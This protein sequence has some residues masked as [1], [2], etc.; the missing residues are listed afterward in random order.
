L[1][2]GKSASYSELDGVP[3]SASRAVLTDLLRDR[4][5][6]TGTTVSD[7]VAVGF[8]QSRQRVAV[9]AVGRPTA[10]VISMGGPYALAAVIDEL[11][12]VVTDSCGG[13]HQGTALA[14]AIFGVTNPGG[15][16]P[17]TLPRHV[18]RSRSTTA[19]SGA[20]A[21]GGPDRT[22]TTATSTCA[23]DAA[24]R[25]RPRPQL[26]DLRVRTAGAGERRRRR[27]RRSEAI[28]RRHQHG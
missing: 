12:A 14:E 18:G 26:H 17:F 3:V 24:L 4:M 13:P 23:V 2:S 9:T 1:K 16:L 8:L 20:A 22:S 7:Y 6:F 15:K 19:R 5:G 10:A 27:G 11:P 25:V 28:T 21:T